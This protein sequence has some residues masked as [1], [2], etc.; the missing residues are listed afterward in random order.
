MADERDQNRSEED[1]SADVTSLIE[2]G[3]RS[4]TALTSWNE[5]RRD[6][7]QIYDRDHRVSIEQLITMRRSDGQARAINRLVTLPVRIAL[8]QGK[9]VAPS[10][11]GGEEEVEFA[12]LMWSL[13]P[14]LGGMTTPASALADQIL[15]ASCDGFAPFE[16]VSH[17]PKE[18]PLKGMKTLRKMAYRDPR[19]VTLLQDSKGGYAGFK[20]DVVD[21]KGKHKQVALSPAKTAL[22]TVN[23]HENPFYGVSFFESAYPHYEAK[24]KWYYISEQAGQF[25][26][27]PGRIGTVP[28]AAKAPDVMAFKQALENFYFNTTM[29]KKEGYTVDS[30]NSMSGFNFMGYI[31]HHNMMMAKSVLASFFES[32]Q[33]T[34]LVENS[35]EDA[36]ADI[37]LLAMEALAEDFASVLTNHVMPKY[38]KENFKNSDKFPVFKPGPLSDSTRK[39]ISDL[40]RT[41]AVSGILNT[42]PELVR[43]LE[44]HV[45]GELGL[46]VDYA[47]IERREQEAAEQQALQA[48]ALAQQAQQ[49][50]LD[51]ERAADGAIPNN[52]NPTSGQSPDMDPSILANQISTPNGEDAAQRQATSTG[53]GER[54]KVPPEANHG[55]ALS[56]SVG[57]TEA[58]DDL[59]NLFKSIEAGED[60]DGPY[61]VDQGMFND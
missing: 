20:Q 58:L 27:V 35:T 55:V 36:S 61:P 43:E 42:T 52:P 19:T 10:E 2:Y 50:T 30:F 24:M 22:F 47:D 48:E 57:Y 29:L 15:L 59:Y 8:Q 23:G 4:N 14:V 31:D 28:R 40:F 3:T 56:D 26:A 34:V 11:G 25:A 38:I 17:V 32:E 18:G 1:Y 53:P 54:G 51:M 33:R 16:L 9:W 44:K 7:Y 21:A 13:P 37:F 60:F 49:E 46:N 39:Q 12:N 41:V 6:A 45:A 5:F